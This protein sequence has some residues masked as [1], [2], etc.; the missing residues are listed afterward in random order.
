MD[1][2]KRQRRIHTLKRLLDSK[3][4]TIKRTYKKKGGN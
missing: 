3:P 4:K 2:I 1:R